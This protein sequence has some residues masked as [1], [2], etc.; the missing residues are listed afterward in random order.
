M[1]ITTM[2]P[3]TGLTAFGP[4]RLLAGVGEAD[5]HDHAHHR[6]VHGDLVRFDHDALVR[7]AATVGLRGRGGAAFPVADKLSGTPVAATTEVVVN[8]SEGE[9]ASRKDRMLA[10]NAPHLVIDGAI[11]VAQALRATRITVAVRDRAAADAIGRA[12][13]GRPD[14]AHVALH[15]TS[16]RFVTGEVRA[17]IAGLDGGPAVPPGRRTLPTVR[18]L[19]GHPTFASNAETFAHLGLLATHGPEWYAA[20]GS[21]GERGTTLLTL[22][23]A[24]EHPGVVEAPLGI[25]L[26]R[27]LGPGDGPVLIG[28]S[29]GTWVHHVGGLD[30][31]RDVLRSRGGQPGRALARRR[32][33]RTVRAVLLRAALRRRRRGR[34]R[35]RS[36]APGGP[37]PAARTSRTA[38]RSRRV[39]PPRWR[40]DVPRLGARRAPGRD[41]PAPRTRRVRALLSRRPPD[42]IGAGAMTAP[43]LEI[44]WTRC[45][46]H[47]LCARLLAEVVS[48]DENGFPVLADGGVLDAGE[49]GTARLAVRSCPA[50]ALRVG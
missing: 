13:A 37:G 16:G 39:R 38:A 40:R 25:G 22:L 32:E 46:G 4:A 19:H 14:A 34:D 49:L 18:G 21:T 44:D 48:A 36:A 5:P 41:R 30:L 17:L 24:V 35:C 8:L 1:T 2:P 12:L 50:L 11:A 47:G 42:R 28:G 27:L 31:D 29:H 10:V 15:I 43:R 20:I 7:A 3:T 45:D 23:G 6:Q 26:D 33:F 9:P